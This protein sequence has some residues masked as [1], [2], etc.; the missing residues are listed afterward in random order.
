MNTIRRF[1]VVW[2]VAIIKAFLSASVGA[3][4]TF[5]TSMAGLEWTGLSGTNRAIVIIGASV[6]AA[7]TLIA[8]LDRSMG[9]IEKGLPP[10]VETGD[11]SFARNQ[12]K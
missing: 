4:T 3:A 12:P 8:F 5:V 7:N 10:V 6:T 2:G 11:T 9:R 1:W